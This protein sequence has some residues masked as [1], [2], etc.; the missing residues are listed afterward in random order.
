MCLTSESWCVALRW[1]KKTPTAVKYLKYLLSDNPWVTLGGLRFK[2]KNTGFFSPGQR[3]PEKSLYSMC[4]DSGCFYKSCIVTKK[5]ISQFHAA[6]T[7]V[8]HK[9]QKKEI[10][11]QIQIFWNY[12]WRAIVVWQDTKNHMTT[13]LPF[14]PYF[15]SWICF[16]QVLSVSKHWPLIN[17]CHDVKAKYCSYNIQVVFRLLYS[18]FFFSLHS[19]LWHGLNRREEHMLTQTF[20]I[21]K[22]D[23]QFSI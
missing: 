3:S 16:N 23:F 6:Y 1:P 4:R 21:N 2:N 19:D 18:M 22:S 17:P 5:N 15:R 7:Q 9:M 20:G 13:W 14:S 10:N 12:T 11:K 8:K